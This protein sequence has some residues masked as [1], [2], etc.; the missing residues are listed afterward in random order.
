MRIPI[1]LASGILTGIAFC[2]ICYAAV[3]HLALPPQR[4]EP[5]ETALPSNAPG[6]A[7]S[8]PGAASG[9]KLPSAVQ[10]PGSGNGKRE[11]ASALADSGSPPAAA[12]LPGAPGALSG[13]DELGKLLEEKDYTALRTAM[14]RLLRAGERGFPT[15]AAFLRAQSTPPSAALRRD[16]RLRLAILAAGLQNEDRAAELCG[17]LLRGL[18][19]ADEKDAELSRLVF[20]FLP[21]FLAS[22]GQRYP[23]LRASFEGALLS[24]LKAQ[25]GGASAWRSFEALGELGVEVPLDELDAVLSDPTRRGLHLPALENLSKRG[26]EESL[27]AI[28]RYLSGVERSAEVERRDLSALR[29]AFEILSRAESPRAQGAIERCLSSPV[30]EV[31]AAATQGYFSRTRGPEALPIAREFLLSDAEPQPKD[32]LI[33]LVRS[34][35]PGVFEALQKDLPSLPPEVS[36][37]IQ[38]AVVRGESRAGHS[39]ASPSKASPL[40]LRSSTP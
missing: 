10:V 23:A 30:R 1:A 29:R 20:E 5:V 28:V 14:E 2:L 19:R 21:T 37:A 11:A 34:S 40:P 26:D 8:G 18:D 25:D 36:K 4:A 27:D 16:G 9:S 38:S 31:R 33:G 15:L 6:P 7:S 13:A 24:D 32:A 22:T 35:S 39:P 17:F 12:P 3:R